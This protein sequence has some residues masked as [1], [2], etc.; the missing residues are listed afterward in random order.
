S[1]D[2]CSSDLGG[3]YGSLHQVRRRV[4][5]RRAVLSEVWSTARRAAVQPWVPAPVAALSDSHCWP[6]RER[7]RHFELC[8]R[9]VDRHHLLPHRQTALRALPCRAVHRGL[10]RIEYYSAVSGG[11]VRTGLGVWRIQSVWR[12]RSFRR[13]WYWN[14]TAKSD[15]TSDVRALD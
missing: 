8:P 14:H 12:L 7:R 9:L 6:F 13:L 15:R 2:V 3:R 4:T 5:R 1:S 11:H 10:W